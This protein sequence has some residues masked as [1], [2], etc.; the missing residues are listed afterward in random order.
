MASVRKRWTKQTQMDLIDLIL[1]LAGVLLWLSWQSIDSPSAPAV[2]RPNLL[3][4]LQR[5]ERQ[6]PK[7]WLYLVALAGLLGVRALV[8]WYIGS[9]VDWAPSIHV[10]VVTLPFRSD[11]LGRMILFSALSFGHALGVLYLGLLLLSVVNRGASESDAVQ[12]L[13]RRRLFGIGRWP[14]AVQLILPVVVG[15][16]L[17]AA[18]QPLFVRLGM[19]PPTH[20]NRHLWEQGVGVSLGAFFAWK[21]LLVGVLLL[22]LINSYVYLGNHPIWNYVNQT[23]RN[24]LRPLAWA[25]IHFGKLDFAPLI[26]TA[27]VL[28]LARLGMQGLSRLYVSL[29][30]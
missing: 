30:W 22:H 11:Y 13:V 19:A 15:T 6:A 25:P 23:A 27:L 26:G 16:L 2:P 20:T 8:Y 21:W 1:N 5:T 29:P 10:G 17:W 9:A 4:T 3:S 14:V 12:R 28:I 18:V 7:R 24:L